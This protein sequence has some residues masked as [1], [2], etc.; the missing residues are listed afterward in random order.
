MIVTGN[1]PRPVPVVVRQ[2]RADGRGT[3]LFRYAADGGDCA[4]LY[5]GQDPEAEAQGYLVMLIK[6][7]AGLSSSSLIREA[8][9]SVH[10][11]RRRRHPV[12]AYG[13]FMFL[14]QCSEGRAYLC[15]GE[16]Y[17]Y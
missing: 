17:L 8:R 15:V 16:C 11:R 12:L 13:K 3:P 4:T 6:A 1:V 14:L 9:V 7:R 10:R 2:G 5:E